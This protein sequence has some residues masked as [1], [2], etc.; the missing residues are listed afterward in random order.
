MIKEYLLTSLILL[1][2]DFVY[3]NLTKNYFNH[4]IQLIQG[5]P[6]KLNMLATIACY[7]LLSLGIFYFVVQKNLSYLESFSL[8]IFVYGVFDLTSAAIFKNWKLT[9][10]VMD[11]LWGGTLFVLVK[12]LYHKLHQ[13]V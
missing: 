6:I 11:T 7:I 13:I 12:F 5:S 2:L 8:G 10:V 9:T 1:G 3:L 4:Q